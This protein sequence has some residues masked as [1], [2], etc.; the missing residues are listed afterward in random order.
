MRDIWAPFQRCDSRG[1]A[2]GL[3]VHLLWWLLRTRILTCSENQDPRPWVSNTPLVG[4]PLSVVLVE[5]Y[6]P[7]QIIPSGIC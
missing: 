4:G 3:G 5:C 7:M 2:R 1:L 6:N